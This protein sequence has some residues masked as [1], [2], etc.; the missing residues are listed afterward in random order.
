[1][2]IISVT[3]LLGDT[4]LLPASLWTCSVCIKISRMCLVLWYLML[5]KYDNFVIFLRAGRGG[6]GG[7]G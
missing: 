3:Y 2:Y 4:Y 6:G 1:M 7:V 5:E